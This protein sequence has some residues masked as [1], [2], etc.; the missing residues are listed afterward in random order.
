MYIPAG[1]L[2]IPRPERPGYVFDG[3]ES[4]IISGDP[5]PN[6]VIPPFRSRL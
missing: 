5:D 3:W 6:A 1:G 4:L 2:S